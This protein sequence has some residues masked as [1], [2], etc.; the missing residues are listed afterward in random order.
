MATQGEKPGQPG[1]L[2]ETAPR[3]AGAASREPPPDANFI[4]TK[5]YRRFTEFADAVRRECYIGLCYGQPGVGKTLLAR[6][7]SCWHELGPLLQAAR[8]HFTEGRDRADWHTLLL[9]LHPHRQRHPPDGRQG[10]DPARFGVRRR[11]HSRPVRPARPC[12]RP[13]PAAIRRA[14]HHRRSRP[15][16]DRRPGTACLFEKRLWEYAETHGLL[17]EPIR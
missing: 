9:A 13:L 11:P 14:A 17:K 1:A 8:H 2:T 4:V 7:Y 16:Q 3:D 15:A 5:E 10:T 6:R 12:V